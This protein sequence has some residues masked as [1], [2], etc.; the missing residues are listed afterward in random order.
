MAIGVKKTGV[1]T[2]T[3]NGNEVDCFLRVDND[4]T[5][6]LM[7]KSGNGSNYTELFFEKGSN[8]VQLIDNGAL[9]LNSSM[10]KD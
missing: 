5:L 9:T 2:A 7:T 10:F 3:I 8:E 6:C 4:G 1:I